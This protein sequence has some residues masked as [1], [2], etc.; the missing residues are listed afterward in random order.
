MESSAERVSHET[1]EQS[2]E[3]KGEDG[4]RKRPPPL[5]AK[6][7]R[8]SSE[9]PEEKMGHIQ[10]GCI[11]FNKPPIEGDQLPVEANEVHYSFQ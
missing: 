4:E 8:D 5:R 3:D 10:L 11:G 7:K 1:R 2:R 6:E 9:E